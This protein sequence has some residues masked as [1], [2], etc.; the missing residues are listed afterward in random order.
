M[1]DPMIEEIYVLVEAALK[2][3]QTYVDVHAFPFRMT[4]DRLAQADASPLSDFW[5]QLETAFR[6]F[7]ETHSPPETYVSQGRYMIAL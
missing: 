5:H 6:S 7:E 3:G 4:K 1:T 2:N